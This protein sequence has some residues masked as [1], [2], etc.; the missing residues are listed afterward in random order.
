MNAPLIGGAAL[1]LLLVISVAWALI[2]GVTKARIRFLCVVLC[3]AVALIGVLAFRDRLDDL[4]KQFEPQ[5]R[6]F[7]INNGM[8]DLWNFISGSSNIRETIEASGGAFL[9]P[10][11]FLIVF[12]ALQFVTWIVYFI[13]TLLLHGAIKRREERRH[14]RLFRSPVYGV[15]QFIVILFVFLTPVFAYLQFAP[16]AVR[17]ANDADL[18]PANAKQTVTEENAVKAKDHPLMQL[19]G[20][21]GGS[22]VNKAL[23]EMK[24]QGEKTYLA[25]EVESIAGMTGD[26]VTLKNAGAVENWTNKEAEAIRSLAGSLGDSKVVSSLIGELLGQA[27]DKWLAGETFFGMAK[28]SMGEYMDPF[29]N[30]LLADLGHDSESLTA[31]ADDLQTVGDL[32]SV[33]IRDGILTHLNDNDNLV[34]LLTKGTTVKDMIDILKANQTLSNLVPEFTKIGM[35]AVGDMLQL[36]DVNPADYEEFFDEVTDKLNEVLDQINISELPEGEAREQAISDL[37]DKLQEQLNEAGVDVELNDDIIGVYAD[38]I[39]DQFDG[40]EPVTVDQLKELFGIEIP[41]G[42]TEPDPVPEP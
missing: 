32:L 27:T 25:D 10:L 4:Y 15:L 2:R 3:A 22:K 42:S 38:T 21:L 35:K 17:A 20:K 34:D 7:L 14:F 12:I 29:L 1:L 30:I 5:L 36:P 11:L 33:L 39:L 8:E 18:I 6:D 28:P 41:T 13:V 23:T 31:I 16:A 26:V 24:L 40:S 9:A 37:T 19:Y